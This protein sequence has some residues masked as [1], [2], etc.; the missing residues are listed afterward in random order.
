MKPNQTKSQCKRINKLR[1]QKKESNDLSVLSQKITKFDQFKT[2]D[3]IDLKESNK[4]VDKNLF[5]NPDYFCPQKNQDK[6]VR[7]NCIQIS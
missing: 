2:Y 1:S 5:Q 6:K 3:H 4:Q 7:N